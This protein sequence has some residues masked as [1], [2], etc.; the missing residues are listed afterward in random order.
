MQIVSEGLGFGKI[1]YAKFLVKYVSYKIQSYKIQIKLQ[2][3]T[4]SFGACWS[5]SFAVTCN[6]NNITN[7]IFTLFVLAL[8]C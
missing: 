1:P 4:D 8:F 7:D 2:N 3:N 5:N 6:V